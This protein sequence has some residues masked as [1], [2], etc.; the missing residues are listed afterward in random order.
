MLAP[1]LHILTEPDHLV[2]CFAI[3][4]LAGQRASR[5]EAL[6][7]L[8]GLVGAFLVAFCVAAVGQFGDAVESLD[9]FAAAGTLI[10][11]GLLVAIPR[12]SLGPLAMAVALATGVVHGFANGLAAD[13]LL[14]V[15]GAVP[16]AASIALLGAGLATLL[17]APW[18]LIAVRVLGSWTA[19]MGL[20]LLGI[21]LR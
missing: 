14:A 9:A 17:R 3:G 12:L 2:A 15:V 20:I 10:A 8:A 18:G 13:T 6:S 7:L 5:P 16:A 4:L 11:A 1:A 21:A 19:A